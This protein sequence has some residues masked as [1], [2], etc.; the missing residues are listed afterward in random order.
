M[1]TLSILEEKILYSSRVRSPLQKV[2]VLCL[3]LF[4][5]SRTCSSH[6]ER[7]IRHTSCFGTP[8]IIRKNSPNMKYDSAVSTR[9]TQ[10][11]KR[12]WLRHCR[13]YN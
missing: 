12:L 3:L 5:T 1:L 4:R 2:C 8:K 13:S 9:Y 6:K 7:G 10:Q 11:I